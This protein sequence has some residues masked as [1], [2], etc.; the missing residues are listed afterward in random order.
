VK[1]SITAINF[2]AVAADVSYEIEIYDEMVNGS[3]ENRLTRQTGSCEEFGYYSIELDNPVRVTSDDDFVVSVKFTTTGYNRPIPIDINIPIEAG[4]Q[5][6]SLDGTT[7][8]PIGSNTSYPWDIAISARINI[9]SDGASEDDIDDDGVLNENDNC[10]EVANG[11]AMGTCSRGDKAGDPCFTAGEN[12][13]ECGDEGF[14]SMNQEDSDNDWYGDVCDNCPTTPN[15]GQ[16]DSFPPQ[17]NDCG[18]AC[19]CEGDVHPEGGDGDVDGYDAF[20]FKQ[21]FGRSDC[22]TNPPCLR[23][24]EC[25]GDIDGSDAHQFKLDFGRSD[26]PSCI[27][28]SLY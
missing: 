23:D 16:E 5:Y 25:D 4:K 26:C 7:W 18:D 14:C 20:V 13:S 12:V 19:E 9:D 2:W 6:L 28:E 8:L 3:M 24:F 11:S 27:F 17:K 10:P 15:P 21:D 22:A 1:G